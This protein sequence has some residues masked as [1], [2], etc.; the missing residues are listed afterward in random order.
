MKQ[1]SEDYNSENKTEEK[2]DNQIK[3]E[4]TKTQRNKKKIDMREGEK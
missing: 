3:K 4:R 1:S 2:C